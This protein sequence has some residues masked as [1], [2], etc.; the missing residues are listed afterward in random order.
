[1]NSGPACSEP[2]IL[3]SM[4]VAMRKQARLVPKRRQVMPAA[5]G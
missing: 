3:F 1:M 2:E 5:A 4:S